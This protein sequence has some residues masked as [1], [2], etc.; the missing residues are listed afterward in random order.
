MRFAKHFFIGAARALLVIAL[1]HH[2]RAHS[3]TILEAG[4]LA[5]YGTNA[6]SGGGGGGDI[7][8]GLVT[9][10]KFDEGTPLSPTSPSADDTGNGHSVTLN[11]AATYAEGKNGPY[12]F[13]N[14]ASTGNHGS[15][16]AITSGTT[17]TITFW[18][19]L[20]SGGGTYRAVWLQGNS[21]GIYINNTGGN[22]TVD[23]YYNN[24][25][26][27]STGTIALDTWTH[28][29]VV[30]SSGNVTYYLNGVADAS[31]YTSGLS[32]NGT[33]IGGDGGT[34]G[35]P[36]NGCLDSVGIYS[37]ALVQADISA[38]YVSTR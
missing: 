27:L 13:T 18:V 24:A 34:G 33:G 17:F 30:C 25:D 10:W 4:G 35:E 26:H 2:L 14:D 20:A 29:A 12:C 32:F 1:L 15:I 21:A 7:T 11:G 19:K 5:A 8:T 36:L 28:V 31:T 6:A 37:R 9:F 22:N 16:T 38:S 23:F 3:Q